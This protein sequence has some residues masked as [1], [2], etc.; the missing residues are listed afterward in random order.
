MV[1]L[2]IVGKF[3]KI[4]LIDAGDVIR[5]EPEHC[6][7]SREHFM[8]KC[9]TDT[10]DVIGQHRVLRLGLLYDLEQNQKICLVD[11]FES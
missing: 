3:H 2:M 9:L 10:C 7:F 8:K 6:L 1:P 4:C 5:H 11:I